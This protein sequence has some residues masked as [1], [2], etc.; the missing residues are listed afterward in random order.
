MPFNSI[1]KTSRY[2]KRQEKYTKFRSIRCLKQAGISKDKKSDCPLLVMAGSP[3]EDAVTACPSLLGLPAARTGTPATDRPFSSGRL[4]VLHGAVW[5]GRTHSQMLQPSSILEFQE[6]FV[7]LFHC[8][9]S[10]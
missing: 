4:T 3:E 10:S 6:R 5:R 7:C 1:F 8:L 2:L 9:T